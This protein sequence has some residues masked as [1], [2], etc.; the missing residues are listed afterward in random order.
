MERMTFEVLR[1]LKVEGAF[2]QCQVNAWDSGRIVRLAEHAGVAWS[3]G[4]HW[5][6]LHWPKFGLRH[7][8]MQ[9]SE[10]LRSS[11]SL[12]ALAP[13]ACGRPT[14]LPPTS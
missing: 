10:V 6:G 12:L 1:T 2:V 13:R 3:I 9:V 14:S 7:A 8:V 11:A 4:Y 5:R